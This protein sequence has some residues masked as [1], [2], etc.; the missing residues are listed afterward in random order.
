MSPGSSPGKMTTANKLGYVAAF[1]IPEVMRG[2]NAFTLGVR[3]SAPEAT[4]KVVWTN[5]WYDPPLERS[6]AEALIDAG[7]DVV[8]QHQDTAGRSRRR[9]RAASTASATTPTWL[10][11]RPRP[12]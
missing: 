7:V 4:V 1:P 6:A 10:R 9:R 11:S 3:Q 8:A 2:I 5:T 12:S